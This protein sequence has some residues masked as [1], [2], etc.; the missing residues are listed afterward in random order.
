MCVY[1]LQHH[2]PSNID[3]DI[4][5]CESTDALFQQF[6]D[7][8]IR[9]EEDFSAQLSLNYRFTKGHTFPLAMFLNREIYFSL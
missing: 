3:L 8:T 6:Q 9:L 1:L 4:S 2:C 5:K 7:R